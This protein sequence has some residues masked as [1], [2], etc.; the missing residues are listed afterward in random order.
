LEFIQCPHCQKKYAANDQLRAAVGKKIRCKHCSQGF[1]IQLQ[2][3]PPTPQ[4]SESVPEEPIVKTEESI[5][6]STAHEQPLQQEQKEKQAEKKKPNSAVAK[7]VTKKLNI[8][9]LITIVLLIVL[10][11]GA[12]GAYLFFNKDNLF[13]DSATPKT[14]SIIPHDLIKPIDIKSTAP[15]ATKKTPI[16]KQNVSHQS[17]PIVTAPVPKAPQQA[18]PERVQQSS[19]NIPLSQTC[20]DISADYWLRTHTLATVSMDTATYMKLLNQNLEQANAIRTVCK[21]K[22]LISKIAKAARVN[23]KPSWIESEIDL[24]IHAA[25]QQ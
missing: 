8:Q 24:R 10:I 22:R 18:I 19:E 9:L 23:Q 21:D 14:E 2:K 25:Q 7:K 15:K 6:A 5:S 16:T 11:G 17:K 3:L 13:T 1:E 20:K 12:I 4:T